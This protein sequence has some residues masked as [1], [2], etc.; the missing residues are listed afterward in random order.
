MH[1]DIFELV[2]FFCCGINKTV[3]LNKGLELETRPS[4]VKKLAILPH[5]KSFFARKLQVFYNIYLRQY[6]SDPCFKY[7]LYIYL[8]EKQSNTQDVP[9]LKSSRNIIQSKQPALVKKSPH[10]TAKVSGVHNQ[11]F[12]PYLLL[13]PNESWQKAI[14]IRM[15]RRGQ[16]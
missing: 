3:C 15:F 16:N 6:I 10:V 11:K 14:H 1:I 9:H 2:H 7:T 13:A 8:S 12:Q 4:S 5:V